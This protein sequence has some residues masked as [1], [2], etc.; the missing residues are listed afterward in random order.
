LHRR[1]VRFYDLEQESGILVLTV[2]ENSPASRSFIRDGDI[3]VTIDGH[4]VA[5]IDD[6]HRLLTEEKA[7]VQTVLT[8][9]RHTERLEIKLTPTRRTD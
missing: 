9:L 8:V 1:L 3:I 4:A 6:L 2:E 5:G 7:G